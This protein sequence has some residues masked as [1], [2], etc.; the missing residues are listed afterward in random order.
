M[1]MMPTGSMSMSMS[2]TAMPTPTMSWAMGAG[3]MGGSGMGSSWGMNPSM[4]SMPSSTSPVFTGGA[5]STS[6]NVGGLAGLVV[7]ALGYFL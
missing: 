6:K 5:S 4:S 2:G 3:H 7:A 1:G